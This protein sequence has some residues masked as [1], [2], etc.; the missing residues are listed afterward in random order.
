VDE[1]D[2]GGEGRGHPPLQKRCKF[3]HKMHHK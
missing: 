3:R 1:R 2:V